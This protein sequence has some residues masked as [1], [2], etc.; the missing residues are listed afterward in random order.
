[1][2]RLQR[3][4]HGVT[5]SY[6]QLA[7]VALYSLATVPVALQY[8]TDA[9]FGLWAVMST[10]MGY[11]SLVD[12]G[13]SSS[14]ARFL[15]DYK[16]KREGGEY[17]GLIQTGGLVLL[18]QALIILLV[19]LV[20]ADSL[21]TLLKVEA[22]LRGEFLALLRLQCAV[23]AFGF[24]TRIASHVLLAHQRMDLNNYAGTLNLL[25]AFVALWGLFH[26][27]WGVIS[28]AWAALAGTL[29]STGLQS[30]WCCRLG[31]LPAR[32][33]WGRVSRAHFYAL[34]GYG[35][36]VFLVAVG[37]QLILTSQTIVVTR[38]LGLDAAARW[39]VGT[40]LFNLV[41]QV[42]WRVFDTAGPAFAEM[43]TRGEQGRL[44]LRYRSMVILTASLSGVAA[45]VL[46]LC[47]A[48][49]VSLW[50][51]GKIAWSP[52]CDVLLGVWL[53]ILSIPHC[54]ISFILITKQ[55]GTMRY[56]FLC[57]GLLFFGLA[58]AVAPHLGLAG[59]LAT[60]ILCSL[61]L[62]G[63]YS[64]L[65]MAHYL[66]IARREL[67][68]NWQKP[69]L[70]VLVLLVPTA[71]GLAWVGRQM[72]LLPGL[73]FMAV[74]AALVGGALLLRVGLDPELKEEILRR[75]PPRWQPL[76]KRSMGVG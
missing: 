11:L 58:L 2:S 67:G 50:T 69:M 31:L 5:S 68:W 73:A 70:K 1:M 21:A 48:P 43:N 49:F 36:D 57:E 22:E 24:A 38:G 27:G 29:V 10:L 76:A 64:V 33:Q 40:R 15:I 13:M 47:N 25:V 55:I 53:I 4:L 52:R 37:A 65:R 66:G 9:R 12:L 61:S 20:F 60:S 39:S 45:V 71:L 8:L 28:M 18:V 56:V 42:I 30:W 41:C 14:V 74:S 16:D 44:R 32:G 46:A 35:K 63:L 3:V 23:V 34:F 51:H 19:G 75:T 59:I 54:H 26:L 62:S 17:G 6:F 72:P 7:A